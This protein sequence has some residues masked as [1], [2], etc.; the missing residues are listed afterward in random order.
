MRTAFVALALCACSSYDPNPPSQG[1][2][3]P[4]S[5]ANAAPDSAFGPTFTDVDAPP[6]PI[7]GGTLAVNEAYAVAA[8]PDRD[9]VYIVS[10]ATR[11]VTTVALLAND[12]PGRVAIDAGGYAHV[13]LRR[14]GAVVTIALASGMIV[15]RRQVCSAPRGVAYDS[16]I[17]A[18]WL[19]CAGGELFA[20]PAGGGTPTLTAQLPR[21]LRDVVVQKDGLLVTRFRDADVLYVTRAGE[22]ASSVRVDRGGVRS[23]AAWRATPGPNGNVL[24]VHQRAR[25]TLPALVPGPS[26]YLPPVTV[27]GR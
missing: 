11:A 3:R 12:E 2:F 13:A 14:G 15:E 18:V 8:D 7:S 21:D 10:L 22:L 1:R 6:P 27:D 20:L 5:P 24:V 9:A 4:A 16:L 19:A 17:D 23:V 25:T 26:Y